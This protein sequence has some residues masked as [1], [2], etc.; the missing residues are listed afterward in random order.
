MPEDEFKQQVDSFL[1]GS[2]FDAAVGV[3]L[4]V[5]LEKKSMNFYRQQKGAA[6]DSALKK[7]FEFLISQEEAHFKIV[8]GLRQKLR[9]EKG[10]VD[11]S[12]EQLA[13]SKAA[14][15]GIFSKDYPFPKISDKSKREALLYAVEWEKEAKKFYDFMKE[16]TTEPDAKSL[17]S[18]LAEF[19]E[20]H[21]KL[22]ES[23]L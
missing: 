11:L 17:F 22:L 1:E 4:A 8:V 21:I 20:G 16:N 12:E 5:E 14:G 13:L 2:S 3:E 9:Q 10:W 18:E 23:V 7:L 15:G 6:A 19:E